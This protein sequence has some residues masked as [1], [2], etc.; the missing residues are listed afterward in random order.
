LRTAA[1]QQFFEGCNR[2]ITHLLDFSRRGSDFVF[3]SYVTDEVEAPLV[4]FA[5]QTLP[6]VIFFSALLA[7][8]YHLGI[9]Q[10]IVKGIAWIMQ[11]TM[12]TSGAET[13]SVAGNIFV[14]QTESPLLIRPYV[15]GMTKSELLTVMC[16]GFATIA[17]GVMAIYVDFL[18]DSLP[19][20]A[21]HLMAASV[22]SAPAA[23]VIAKILYPETEAPATHGTLNVSV[24][25]R[26]RNVLEAVGDGATD[27]MKL[28]LNIAA[29]LIAFVALIALVNF[30][31]GFAGLTLEQ[32]LGRVF[33][34]LAWCMGADWDEAPA[35][36]Q[37]LGEKLVLTELVAYTR[38]GEMRIGTDISERTYIIASYALCGFANFASIGIQLGGIGGIAPERKADLAELAFKAMIGGALASWM[39]ASIAGVLIT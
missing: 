39:T 27:G 1:G 23:L 20:I 11:R 16:G 14:G 31:L 9:M 28:C 29:M 8:L 26:S 5:F 13:L 35:L 21:G 25:R 4:N 2:V 38:L 34:P 30:L 33:R 18:D 17:G 12:G 32:I 22:M 7:V 15:A 36:G 6:T 37:L 19:D 3:K 24:E 10:L